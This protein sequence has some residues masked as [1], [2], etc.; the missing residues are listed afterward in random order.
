MVGTNFLAGQASLWVQPKGP[1]TEPKYL[2][3]HSVGDIPQPKGDTTQLWCPDPAKVGKFKVKNSFK[4]EPGAI[5]TTIETDLRKTADYL[6][7]LADNGCPFPLFVHKVSCGRRDVFTNFDRSFVL[8][9]V[10]ITSQT[11]SNLAARDP[12]NE[13][14]ST[15]S[16]DISA[17]E[18][19]RIFN[20]DIS[21]ISVTE[22][23]DLTSIAVGGEDRCEGSCGASQKPE[24]DL[25]VSSKALLGSVSNT[26]DVLR[27]QN[28]GAWTATPAD[29]FIG[30][31]DISGIAVLSLGRNIKRIL[32]S[33]G[34]TQVS[35]PA[36]IAYSD[37][38]GATWS[39]VHV[40]TTNAEFITALCA[41]DRYNIWIG[42]DTGKI[43]FSSDAGI[44]WTVQENASISSSD[45]VGISVLDE[46][47]AVALFTGGEVAI[48]RDG[49][50]WS[51]VTVSGAMS[52]TSIKIVTPYEIWVTGSNGLFFSMDGGITWTQRESAALASVDFLNEMFGMTVGSSANGLVYMTFN[53]GYD[54]IPLTLISNSGFTAVKIL[55]TKLAFVAGKA[56]GGTAF[57]GK[58][59]PI[60]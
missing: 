32:V 40:G 47:N 5:T 11:L 26:A 17:A 43:Y 16:F 36:E 24:D 20:M 50:T 58:V 18:V 6:E 25:Y 31:M 13:G 23:E 8:R 2:G 56:H 29:P 19:L 37:D 51:A 28:G 44:T 34:T 15:Q 22:T 53:G 33:N 14:E 39:T 59:I 12:A 60:A 46:E 57:L 41:L 27:S 52:A 30:G 10:E 3:C 4:G 49:S 45:V 38:G 7:N 9:Q 42:T 55:S 48:T 35:H 1:N 54:W 21:R